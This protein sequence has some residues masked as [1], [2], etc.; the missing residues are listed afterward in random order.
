M[1]EVLAAR[2]LV[3]V[4][5]VLGD[6]GDAPRQQAFQPGQGVVGR[7]G[8]DLGLLQLL[9]TRVVE[10]LH[11]LGIPGITLGGGHI[12]NPVL[13][14]QAVTGPECLDTGLGRDAGTGE[15]HDMFG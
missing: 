1:D 10:A 4:V 15:D 9:A 13:L 14:P 2:T 7:I 8:V 3:Q 6:Q 11:Q 12:L 5:D